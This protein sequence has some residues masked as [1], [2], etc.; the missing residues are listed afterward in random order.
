MAEES[1]QD[2]AIMETYEE[3][4]VSGVQVALIADPENGKAWIQSDVTTPVEP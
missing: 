3:Y 1:P 2:G 4:T